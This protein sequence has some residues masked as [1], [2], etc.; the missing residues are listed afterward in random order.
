[1]FNRHFKPNLSKTEL[2]TAHLDPVLLSFLLP[3]L[4]SR[5]SGQTLGVSPSPFTTPP[6]HQ[7]ILSTPATVH[8]GYFP[9]AATLGLS[10][11]FHLDWSLTVPSAGFPCRPSVYFL[12]FFLIKKCSYLFYVYG[13]FAGIPGCQKSLLELLELEL[14]GQ[15]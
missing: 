10:H 4:T 7:H 9:H 15:L 3:L 6:T 5:C 12:S 11:C 8:T 1:M 14:L 2:P 13:Y